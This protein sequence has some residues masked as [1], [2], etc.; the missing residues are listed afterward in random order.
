M[1]LTC[2]K[3]LTNYSNIGYSGVLLEFIFDFGHN[4]SA[5]HMHGC[6]FFPAVDA[7]REFI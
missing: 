2:N 7:S 3:N 5:T 6:I 4:Y 1:T